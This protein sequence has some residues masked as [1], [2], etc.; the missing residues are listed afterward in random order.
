[1]WSY[2]TPGIGELLSLGPDVLAAEPLAHGLIDSGC[3]GS[4]LAG[5]Q[6]VQGGSLHDTLKIP[7]EGVVDRQVFPA[8]LQVLPDRGQYRTATPV[9][10]QMGSLVRGDLLVQRE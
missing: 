3:R 9:E 8:V 1:M 5:C 4:E 2:P 10:P 6:C 7:R